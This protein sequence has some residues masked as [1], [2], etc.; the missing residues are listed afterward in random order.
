M[1]RTYKRKLKLSKSQEQR[2]VGWIGVC[3][4]VYNM[5]LEI[6]K[7]AY[8]G[9]GKSVHKFELMKQ[10]KPLRE[11]FPWIEDVPAATLQ[12]VIDRL[13]AA[14]KVFFKG[15]GFPKFAN[16]GTYKS[17][18]FKHIKVNGNCVTLPKIGKLR[19]FKDSHINGNPKRAIIKVEPTGFFICIQCDNVPKK[20]NSENQAI[21]LDMGLTH[22]CIDSNGKFISNPKHFKKYERSI[23]IA[24]RS[25]A[26]K[27]KGSNRW[28]EQAKNLSRLHHII[29]NVRNDFL[30]KESTKIAKENS[31]VY[32]EDLKISNMVK[33]TNLSKHILDAGWGIF[34]DM[35]E[36]KTTG[37]RVD[38]KYT[39]QCCNVCGNI[40]KENRVSQSLFICRGC[41]H[42]DNADVNAAKNIFSRGTAVVRKRELTDCALGEE[43]HLL[44]MPEVIEIP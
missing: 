22:F 42:M 13:D 16:K 19:I 34:R 38:H 6:R 12:G 9:S 40:S 32:L 30:H 20:F 11:E 18:L 39:S 17:I 10:L 24:N 41:G 15:G 28:K 29:A 44:R 33:N 2:L 25:L 7:I 1:I 4:L 43:P 21:G 5:S 31:V 37:I 8:N 35:L 14:Y 27:K 3:R 36:Y 26:R 23:R